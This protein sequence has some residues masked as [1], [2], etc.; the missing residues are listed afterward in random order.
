[1]QAGETPLG[2]GAPK[3]PQQKTNQ[4]VNVNTCHT[5]EEVRPQGEHVLGSPNKEQGAGA[6]GPRQPRQPKPPGISLNNKS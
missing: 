5:D 2:P 4:P 1:M 3:D 6:P